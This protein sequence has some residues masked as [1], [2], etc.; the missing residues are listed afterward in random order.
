[1]K[2][3]VEHGADINFQNLHEQN[4]P[5]SIGFTPLMNAAL[6]NDRESFFSFWKKARTQTCGIKAVTLH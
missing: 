4:L 6:G 1:M 2:M 5:A 3:L